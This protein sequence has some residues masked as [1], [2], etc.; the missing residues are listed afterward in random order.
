MLFFLFFF[1]Y[2]NDIFN[3]A[4]DPFDGFEKCLCNSC[5]ACNSSNACV[6]MCGLM[7]CAKCAEWMRSIRWNRWNIVLFFF[8]QVIET[9]KWNLNFFR[10]SFQKRTFKNEISEISDVAIC[11]VK[12]RSKENI[13]NNSVFMC[14]SHNKTIAINAFNGFHRFIGLI[15]L[16]AIDRNIAFIMLWNL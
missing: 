5:N 2:W 16:M 13:K 6:G 9:N 1:F 14:I 12:E 10:L 7:K 4:F 15:R 11:Y 3:M 8:R